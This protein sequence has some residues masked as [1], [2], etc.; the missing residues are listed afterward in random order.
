MQTYEKYL[1]YNNGYSCTYI[2]IYI[3]LLGGKC[4]CSWMGGQGMELIFGIFDHRQSVIVSSLF[5]YFEAK[6]TQK[7]VLREP[8]KPKV[9]TNKNKKNPKKPKTTSKQ[10]TKN[11]G[12]YEWDFGS[13]EIDIQSPRRGSRQSSPENRAVESETGSRA[14]KTMTRDE[15]AFLIAVGSFIM[16]LGWLN[17]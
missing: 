10:K 8:A 5:L 12:S 3:Y 17:A 14:V 11:V 16:D 9:G 15:S 1:W 2:Y 7:A 4:V 13:R 6:T